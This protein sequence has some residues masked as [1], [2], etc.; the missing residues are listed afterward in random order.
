MTINLRLKNFNYIFKKVKSK[1]YMYTMK[2]IKRVILLLLMAKTPFGL[3]AQNDSVMHFSLKEA[4][5]Y[6]IQNFYVSKNAKLDIEKAKKVVLETTAIGLPQVNASANWVYIPGTIPTLDFGSQLG[7]AFNPIY[8]A[9]QNGGLINMDTVNLSGGGPS[10]IAER[11]VV[12]YGFTVSQLIFSGEYIVGLQAS[13]VYKSLSEE[14]NVKTEIEL[15]QSIA[16]SYFAVLILEK[17]KSILEKMIINL[18]QSLDQAKKTNKAGFLEDTDVD[19]LALTVSRTENSLNTIN[20]QIEVMHRLFKYQLGMISENDINLTDELDALISLNIVNDSTYKF[21]LDDN[22]DYKLLDTQEK[23]MKLNL[24]REKTKYLPTIA[25]FY[26][27]QD[28]TKKPALDFTLKHIIGVSVQVP[29]FESGSRIA[30]VSQARIEYEKTQNMKEQEIQRIRMGADQSLYDY[31][32]ALEKYTNEK[33]NF[34]LSERVYNKSNEKFKQ[35]MISSLDLTM[36]NNQYLQAQMSYAMSVQELLS[37]KVKLD[38]AY[39]QL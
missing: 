14:T 31:R 27:Y 21:L 17:N 7:E 19:Q 23:L 6:A 38:K 10:P 35:G 25:G 13:K 9:L 26:Q 4:Q 2:V 24:S 15:K 18:N 5:D 1:L 11:S 20:R 39:N 29:I 8:A 16:D 34:E 37:A 36:I 12:T 28:K 22:I 33:S 30:K 32:S 3:F